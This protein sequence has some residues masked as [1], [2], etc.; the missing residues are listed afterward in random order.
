[1]P[2]YEYKCPTCGHRF[3]KLAKF[4]DPNPPCPAEIDPG[5]TA[6]KTCGC[7]TVKMVSKGNFALKGSGWA[8]DDYS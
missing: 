6:P 3:E 7:I 1:M 8:A 5:R 4:D 2:I